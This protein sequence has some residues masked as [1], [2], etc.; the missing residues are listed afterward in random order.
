[1]TPL[2]GAVPAGRLRLHC[3]LRPGC[4]QLYGSCIVVAREDYEKVRGHDG[5][6]SELLD[7]LN[8]GRQFRQAGIPV[9][10]Y[11]GWGMVSFRMYPGGIVSELQGFGKGAVL[12]TAT[13]HGGTTA[14]I[15][16]WIVGLIAVGFGAPLMTALWHPLMPWFWAGYALYTVQLFWFMHYT[17]RYGVLMPSSTGIAAVLHFAC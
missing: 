3:A 11:M 10:N 9:K 4:P 2:A 14:L 1:M 16:L 13:L 17:G 6:R 7:D 8:L 15:A 12:S 5:I